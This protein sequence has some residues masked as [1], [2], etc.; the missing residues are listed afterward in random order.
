[1]KL[2]TAIV[3]PSKLDDVIEALSSIG[4]R[5]FT[6]TEAKGFGREE[7]FIEVYRAEEYEVASTPK[8]RIDTAI[9]DDLVGKVIET[10]E[11]AARTGRIG[12]GKIFVA[13]LDLTIRVRTGE[14]DEAAL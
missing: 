14:R 1:M 5:G 3:R 13:A 11:K 8:V 10:V 12:D 2:V 7:G 9:P 4:V 6:V